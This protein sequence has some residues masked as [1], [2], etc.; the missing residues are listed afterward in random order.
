MTLSPNKALDAC[1]TLLKW[2]LHAELAPHDNLLVAGC[3]DGSEAIYLGHYFD[4]H[5]VGVDLKIKKPQLFGNVLIRHGDLHVVEDLPSACRVIFSFHVIEHVGDPSIVVRNLHCI[6]DD[7]G[8]MLIGFPNKLRLFGYIDSR[9]SLAE[10]LRWNLKDM[11]DRI[12]FKFE[13]ELGAHAGFT[14]HQFKKIAQ[15]LFRDCIPVTKQYISLKYKHLAPLVILLNRTGLYK[16]L[17]PSCY[18]ILRK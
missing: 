9:A 17:F 10:K 4:C 16:V 11:Y 2:H 5:V 15:P 3:G 18:F 7:D 1:I 14:H 12:T 13:N 8:T 6:L